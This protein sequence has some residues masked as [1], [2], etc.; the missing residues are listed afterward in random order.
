MPTEPGDI[1]LAKR[2]KNADDGKDRC[3]E[4]GERHA[5]A[6]RRIVGRAR[7]HHQPA[8]RLDD[9]VH[10]FAGSGCRVIG[11]VSRYRAV[12][13][14]RIARARELVPDAEP[15]ERARREVLDDDI[16][17]AHEVREHFARSRLL[18]V[19]RDR[20]LAAQAVQS[21]G[22]NVVRRRAAERD[23]VS[24]DERRV[25]AAVIGRGGVLDLDDARAEARQQKC[26]ERSRQRQRQVEHCQS[27]QWSGLAVCFGCAVH[28]A[29]AAVY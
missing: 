4:I 11:A 22:R 17:L 21:C 13:D 26:R 6:N 28:A 25:L 24:P 16:R 2:R 12:D 15:I 18:Q 20:I 7:G 27:G 3:R 29:V 23:A 8:E 14:A 1:A 9:A 5:D 19:Q 10:G